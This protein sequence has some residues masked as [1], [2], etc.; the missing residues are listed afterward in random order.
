[1]TTGPAN[2]LSFTGAERFHASL[3]G[4]GTTTSLTSGLPSRD[5]CVQPRW[6]LPPTVTFGRS[7]EAQ[8]PIVL[9]FAFSSE[10]GICS[11]IACT[12]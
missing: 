5:T 2:C 9:F 8:T 11:A 1:M 6:S 7:V 4:V 10:I 12:A 3:K